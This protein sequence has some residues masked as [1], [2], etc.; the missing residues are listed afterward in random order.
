[1]SRSQ[2]SREE[3]Q[4]ITRKRLRESALNAFA[5]KGIHGVGIEQIV[6]EAGYTRGAFYSN[7]D[8]KLDMLIDILD[9]KQVKEARLWQDFIATVEDPEK[10]LEHL[11]RQ[12]EDRQQ[13]IQRALIN[14]ELQLEADR[15]EA[16]SS[17]FENY[18]DSLYAE[19]RR[20]YV[21]LLRRYGK[22]PP[23]HLDSLVVTT[24]LLGLGLGSRT[25]LGKQLRS[26][27]SPA[28]VMLDFMR[29]VIAISPE[30]DD[31]IPHAR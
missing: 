4:L 16:F 21:V 10:G 20:F 31:Q 6:R 27:R 26:K 17:V 30:L 11:A 12:Y 9:E 5:S 29:S 19:I 24:R 25:S 22:A 3:S 15:N 14:V 18:L 28:E 2:L 8:S 1:M 13:N 23:E 7:Y